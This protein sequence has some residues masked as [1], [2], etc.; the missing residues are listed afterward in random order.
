M[1]DILARVREE[2]AANFPSVTTAEQAA[3][4]L[5][6]AAQRERQLLEIIHVAGCLCASCTGKDA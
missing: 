4:A 1:T 5:A 6:F 2:T 3:A